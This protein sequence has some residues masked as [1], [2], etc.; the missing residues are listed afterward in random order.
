MQRKKDATGT[1]GRRLNCRGRNPR[2]THWQ[3]GAIDS[4]L[5][6]KIRDIRENSIDELPRDLC[7]ALDDITFRTVT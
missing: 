3:A 5:L 4:R 7:N 2:I 6:R 1:E